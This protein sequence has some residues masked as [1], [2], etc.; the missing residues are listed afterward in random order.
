MPNRTHPEAAEYE[1]PRG[2]HNAQRYR[3]G[4]TTSFA[5]LDG[6]T[7]RSIQVGMPH[8]RHREFLALLNEMVR[9][10]R[11]RPPWGKTPVYLP[12]GIDTPASSE[13]ARLR[14]DPTSARST[15]PY[16]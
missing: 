2:C 7:R 8:H 11:G 12:N 14:I 13:M 6:A 3:H 10:V 1:G 4:A 5:A 15:R 9:R 16:V